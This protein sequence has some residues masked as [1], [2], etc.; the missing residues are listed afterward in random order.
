MDPIQRMVSK[1]L[2]PLQRELRLMIARC[3]ITLVDSGNGVQ[4]M[5]VKL[6]DGEVRDNVENFESYGFTSKPHAGA[7]GL[8]ASVSGNRDHGIVV[9]VGNRKLRL[10][11]METG[12]VA[13][14]TDEGDFIK[15]KRERNIEV[16]SGTKVTITTPIVEMS[17]DL[18]VK[19]NIVADGNISD[20]GGAKSMAGMRETHNDHD[21]NE[22]NT[23]GGPTG[24]A[25]QGM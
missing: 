22:N 3:V 10:T 18:H 1:M 25:N 19:G 17:Q 13:I 5:Q 21:H 4:V 11:G 12:E 9:A 2:A 24:K 16:V 14:Y 20:A 8:F 7:E 23:L 6:L 15:L